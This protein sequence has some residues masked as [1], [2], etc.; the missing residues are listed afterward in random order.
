MQVPCSFLLALAL[1]SG[2]KAVNAGT[3]TG[4]TIF[5]KR[6]NAEPDIYETAFDGVTWDN[7]NW[8]LNTTSLDQGHYQSRMTVANGYHGISVAALGP[9]FEVDTP[10]DGDIIGGWPLYSRRQTF[11]TIGG[12]WD[13][14]PETNASNFDWLVSPSRIPLIL[15]TAHPGI[16]RDSGRPRASIAK[17]LSTEH[18]TS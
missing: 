12:F 7:A 8:R 10:V 4:R 14:Q 16:C 11:A 13:V 17:T 5:Q 2:L 18:S 15:H 6:A 9:F 3:F 1:A